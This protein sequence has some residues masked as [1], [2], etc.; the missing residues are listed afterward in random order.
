MTSSEKRRGAEEVEREIGE[1]KTGLAQ[2]G[3][4]ADAAAIQSFRT[5]LQFL[6]GYHGRVHLISHQDYG[7]ISRR[8]FLPSL[9]GFP[10]LKGRVRVCDIGSGAGFPSVPLVILKHDIDL[11][12]IESV[13]KKASFLTRLIREL[14]LA[15]VEVVN[16]RAE[17]Y[18][19]APFDLALL[20]AVGKIEK[21]LPAVD[22][23][24]ASGGAAI[25]YKAPG[26]DEELRR[27]AR[28][29]SRFGFRAEVVHVTT[30]VEQV[31]MALVILRRTDIE[32]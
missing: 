28:A 3:I 21:L 4:E 11:V 32:T 15:R 17:E 8:H 10:Y 9:L 7:R 27:A 20:K 12:I 18:C 26:V 30:P 5:Y 2:L 6:H 31:P 14:G 29:M 19:G 25:F 22:A 23:L 24:L 13:S 16:A 1:L